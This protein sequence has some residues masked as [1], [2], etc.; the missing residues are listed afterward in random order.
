MEHALSIERLAQSWL[1]IIWVVPIGF[2]WNF[3]EMFHEMSYPRP[4]HN[5]PLFWPSSPSVRRSMTATTCPRLAK[6][7]ALDRKG[8]EVKPPSWRNQLHPHW[9]QLHP[10]WN[11]QN[12][13]DKTFYCSNKIKMRTKDRNCYISFTTRKNLTEKTQESRVTIRE[14]A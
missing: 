2:L 8:L 5:C 13:S 14:R 11:Q 7:Q 10:H 1:T 9:N 3:H 4:I 12:K 6:P